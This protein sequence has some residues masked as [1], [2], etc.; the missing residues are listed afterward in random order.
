M[1][2]QSQNY[3]LNLLFQIDQKNPKILMCLQIQKIPLLQTNQTY[4][5]IQK[6]QLFLIVQR[7]QQCH[8]FLQKLPRR[9]RCI[10]KYCY[11]L[12]YK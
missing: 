11:Q 5:S 6:I 4:L 2:L 3:L 8:Y 1:F 9:Y 7:N 10:C 12:N